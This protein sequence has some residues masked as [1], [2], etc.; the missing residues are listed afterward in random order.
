MP[1]IQSLSATVSREFQRF[2]RNR[3][4]IV[5]PLVFFGL[6][7]TLIALA[8]GPDNENFSTIAPAAAWIAVVLALTL[9]LNAIFS[10]DHDDGS[11][12]QLVLSGTPLA[13]LVSGKMFAHWIAVALPQIGS[14]W[15]FMFIVGIDA[16][17]TYALCLSLIFG[18][19]VLVCVGGIAAALTLGTRSSGSLVA[20]IAL[21]LYMPV[22]IFG[23]AAAINANVGASIAAELY[24]LGGLSVLAVTLC[25]FACAAA[26]RA[27]VAV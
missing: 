2:S 13:L 7:V 3:N 21:P 1:L 25:P 8:I 12:E 5:Q 11:L 6:V 15:L 19:P 9:N 16:G 23:T 26:L 27:R 24:F 14:A 20:L 4:E 22:L 17:V 18:S 10:Q